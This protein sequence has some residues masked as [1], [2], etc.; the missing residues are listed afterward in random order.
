LLPVVMTHWQMESIEGLNAAGER[1]REH[2]LCWMARMQRIA[3]RME[4]QSAD[5]SVMETEVA[6]PVTG[7][8]STSM[9]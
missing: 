6:A 1:A 2:L 9:S 8:A 3:N 7:W 5:T 4:E